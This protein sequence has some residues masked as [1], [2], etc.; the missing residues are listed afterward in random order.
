MTILKCH[1]LPLR[2]ERPLAISLKI[3]SEDKIETRY[4]ALV[5]QPYRRSMQKCQKLQ[6]LKKLIFFFN[7]ERPVVQRDKPNLSWPQCGCCR[8]EV[9]PF[10]NYLNSENTP[11]VQK[12]KTEH[13]LL[14]LHNSCANEVSC[15]WKSWYLATFLRSIQRIAKELSLFSL[16]AWRMV[17]F[18]SEPKLWAKFAWIDSIK[19]DFNGI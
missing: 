12:T 19:L 2:P 18:H 8:T 10:T 16:T 14:Y 3:S 1:S 4:K 13:C 15:K 7:P 5:S 6:I 11:G 9:Y 17:Y